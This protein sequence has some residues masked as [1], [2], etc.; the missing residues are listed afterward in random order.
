MIARKALFAAQS[1]LRALGNASGLYR[2]AIGIRPRSP[3]RGSRA[4]ESLHTVLI[5]CIGL[6]G[7]VVPTLSSAKS[8][9]KC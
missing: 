3:V 2:Q 7:G 4:S 8:E 1:A 9:G 6:E 5:S